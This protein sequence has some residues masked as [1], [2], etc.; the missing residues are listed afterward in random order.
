MPRRGRGGKREGTPGTPYPNRTD[1]SFSDGTAGYMADDIQ[2]YGE[3]TPNSALPDAQ[4]STSGS[5][6]RARLASVQAQAPGR[7][8]PSPES[9]ANLTDPSA[10]GPG[11]LL[12]GMGNMM[13]PGLPEDP[14]E[15]VRALYLKYGFP[16]LLQLMKD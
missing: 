14:H 8:P 2:P 12:E 10:Q 7:M 3:Q 15:A 4:R 6:P 11:N 16:E 5:S 9:T 13:G 1:L